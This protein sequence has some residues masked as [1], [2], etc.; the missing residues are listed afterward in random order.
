[1]QVAYCDCHMT[2]I[3][4]LFVFP[5]MFHLGLRISWDFHCDLEINW[6]EEGG[7]GSGY[8]VDFS[9]PRLLSLPKLD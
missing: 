4:S 7:H 6:G 8:S 3:L 2:E 1:M 9:G 5:N